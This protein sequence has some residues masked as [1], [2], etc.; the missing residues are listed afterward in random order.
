[1]RLAATRLLLLA[2]I[3][4]VSAVS[5][6]AEVTLDAGYTVSIANIPIGK[7]EAKSRFTSNGYAAVIKGSVTGISRLISDGRATLV[8]SGRI[9]G[10]H[11]SP[12]SFT[13]Q[14]IESSLETY[15][16]MSMR[17][18]RITDLFAVPRLKQAADRVP[19]TVADTENVL[20]PV[21]AFLVVSQKPGIAD[22]PRI[23]DRTINVFDGWQRFDVHLFYKETKLI[24]GVGGAYDG[25]VVVCTARYIP[26]AGHRTSH[27]SVKFMEQNKRIEIA[28]APLGKLPYLVPHR[29]L[30]GTKFGDLIVTSNRFI[31]TEET[32]APGN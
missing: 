3:L 21:A 8:G 9:S 14:T 15:V 20:D 27:E 10:T 6:V 16:R 26:I 2:G 4:G 5:A 18:D 24:T 29:I 31:V 30:I 17:G 19:I 7:V 22:G 28:Y 1:M 32:G 12:A 11:V 13:L 25:R 23:C